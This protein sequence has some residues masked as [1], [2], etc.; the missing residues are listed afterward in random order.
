MT[1]WRGNVL[2]ESRHARIFFYS[3]PTGIPLNAV[4]NAGCK[5]PRE[6][7]AAWRDMV[8]TWRVHRAV[9]LLRVGKTLK[10]IKKNKWGNQKQMYCFCFYLLH[11]SLFVFLFM[12]FV[13]FPSL[14][15]HVSFAKQKL[16]TT[17]NLI[18]NDYKTSTRND[19][20]PRKYS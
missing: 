12:L 1:T 7:C 15:L 3:K 2:Y 5:K 11:V 13:M 9:V 14:F 20:P 4:F 19:G 10:E 18:S 17:A 6:Y 8:G 16:R